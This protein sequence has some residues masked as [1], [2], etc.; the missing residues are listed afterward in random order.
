MVLAATS[1]TTDNA[2]GVGHIL[3]MRV[4]TSCQLPHSLH[5]INRQKMDSILDM[6]VRRGARGER[7]HLD[8]GASSFP[9]SRTGRHCAE[10]SCAP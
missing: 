4:H 8:A 1:C 3:S 7:Q 2:H 10:V 6:E 9:H 5:R